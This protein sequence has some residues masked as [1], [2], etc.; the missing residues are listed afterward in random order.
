MTVQRIL[1]L[2]G[3]RVIIVHR[4]TPVAS[5]VAT[6]RR[7]RVG[8]L[9]VSRNG[10]E[11][12]GLVS[13]RDVIR[14]LASIGVNQCLTMQVAD[15]M[16]CPVESCRPDDGLSWVLATMTQRR[17]RHMPVMKNGVLCG[18][19]SIGDVIRHRLEEAESEARA[20]REAF[21]AAR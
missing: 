11:I 3:K 8:A 18:I 20:A 21:M 1:M 13:E 7:E 2:K 9:V 4:D 5:A 16:S 17:V 6:L 14:A 12:Q 10:R 19:I 15:I